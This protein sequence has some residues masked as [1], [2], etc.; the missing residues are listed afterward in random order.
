MQIQSKVLI[1]RNEMKRKVVFDHIL[2]VFK[3]ELVVPQSFQVITE[4]KTDFIPK[5]QT[6]NRPK[7]H[8]F[9]S[10]CPDI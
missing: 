7:H 2:Q 1:N 9:I 10:D 8:S 3:A 4:G 6:I 5:K